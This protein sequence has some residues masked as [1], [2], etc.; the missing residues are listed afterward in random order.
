MSTPESG[1][2][3]MINNDVAKRQLLHIATKMMKVIAESASN[4]LLF[5][6]ECYLLFQR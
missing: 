6:L 4:R 3:V 1:L 2:Q 5:T